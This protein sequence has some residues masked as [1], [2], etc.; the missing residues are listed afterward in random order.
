MHIS[1]DTI[2]LVI[3]LLIFL[4]TGYGKSGESERLNSDGMKLLSSGRAAESEPL[5]RKAIAGRMDVKYYYNN[6]AVSL[7]M[8]KRYPEAVPQLEAALKL[9]R[10][11]IK[12]LSNLAVCY[13]HMARYRESYRYYRLAK[14]L[15]ST[16]VKKR[17]TR[18]KIK[19][20]TGK[21]NQDR[22]DKDEMNEIINRLTGD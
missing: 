19:R 7:M 14:E 9:D 5:F 8:Q 21:I 4:Q 6:L 18:D 11:Y 15:D 3:L 1:K 20:E 10:S 2:K 16:Y 13:F 22:Y 12:A 17:F